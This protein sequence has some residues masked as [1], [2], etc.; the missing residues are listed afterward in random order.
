M[1]TCVLHLDYCIGMAQVQNGIVHCTWNVCTKML[2]KSS[3]KDIEYK[4]FATQVQ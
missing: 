3:S 1:H 2:E 4:T